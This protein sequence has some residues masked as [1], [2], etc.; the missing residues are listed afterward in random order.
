MKRTGVFLAVYVVAAFLF[1]GCISTAETNSAEFVETPYNPDFYQNVET[2]FEGTWDGTWYAFRGGRASC[3]FVF[4]GN[5]FVWYIKGNVFTRGALFEADDNTLVLEIK[6]ILSTNAQLPG[7]YGVIV[8]SKQNN[9]TGM[10]V[11]FDFTFSDSGTLSLVTGGEYAE[12][13]RN[14]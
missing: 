4:R 13:R 14:E 10:K 6:D 9:A 11:N 1:S 2:P 7:I 5:T 12:L 3:R 8:W